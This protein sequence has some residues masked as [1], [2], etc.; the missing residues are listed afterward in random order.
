[1]GEIRPK[2]DLFV[3]SDVA[4]SKMHAIMSTNRG[5]GLLFLLA[6]QRKNPRESPLGFASFCLHAVMFPRRFYQV[7]SPPIEKP[8]SVIAALSLIVATL[9]AFCPKSV[10]GTELK[11]LVARATLST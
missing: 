1:M 9:F 11:L 10:G 2:S 3:H 4:T 5:N 8:W 7:Y 6:F